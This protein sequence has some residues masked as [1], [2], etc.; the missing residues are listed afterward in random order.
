MRV[1]FRAFILIFPFHVVRF[2]DVHHTRLCGNFRTFSK[3]DLSSYSWSVII[4]KRPFVSLTHSDFLFGKTP[5][6]K[7]S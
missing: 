1:P 3:P 5:N 4:S 7:K 6:G 2:P